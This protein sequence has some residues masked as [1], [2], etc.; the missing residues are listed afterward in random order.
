[1]SRGQ[2]TSEEKDVTSKNDVFI[3]ITQKLETNQQTLL[4][5]LAIIET[6]N[7][8]SKTYMHQTPYFP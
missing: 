3:E 1:M 8:C 6:C 7:I 5:E 2:R 4:H